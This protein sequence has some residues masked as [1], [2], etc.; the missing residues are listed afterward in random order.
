MSDLN[1]KLQR[2]LALRSTKF[3]ELARLSELDPSEDFKFADLRNSDFS[4]QDLS[5]FDFSFS[6]LQGSNFKGAIFNDA[7]LMNANFFVWHA[8]DKMTHAER[9][10]ANWSR[11]APRYYQ[12]I[13]A[14]AA[15]SISRPDV[16]ILSI[17]SEIASKDISIY[18]RG[19]A[20]STS[21]IIQDG[22]LDINT[23]RIYIV[24]LASKQTYPLDRQ[25]YYNSLRRMKSIFPILSRFFKN[26]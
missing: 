13:S 3:I 9:L 20:N 26:I 25:R 8:T 4:G 12:R 15:L 5:E 23:K 14:S 7:S 16:D 10:A 24:S 2:I 17:L 22:T 6:H 1:E 21:D 11:L 19:F 18:H